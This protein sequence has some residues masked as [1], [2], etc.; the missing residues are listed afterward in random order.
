MVESQGVGW[1]KDAFL[2]V[3][4]RPGTAELLA[5]IS[6]PSLVYAGANGSF[7]RSGF[8]AS[9]LWPC[10]YFWAPLASSGSIPIFPSMVGVTQGEIGCVSGLPHLTVLALL[11][12]GHGRTPHACLLLGGSFPAAKP[13]S[14]LPSDL[15]A[16][17]GFL[18]GPPRA[19]G[20][21]QG[22]GVFLRD[23]RA[24]HLLPSPRP[25][26]LHLG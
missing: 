11:P 18:S 16:P 13:R 5:L 25:R 19:P 7:S 20:G 2:R 17:L 26:G 23:L 6:V 1:T 24:F 22:T 8:Q 3:T 9:E 12:P 21:W 10:S 14:F 4:C 15:P